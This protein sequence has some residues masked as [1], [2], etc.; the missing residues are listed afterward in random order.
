[1]R[2]VEAIHHLARAGPQPRILLQRFDDQLIDGARQ[3][4]VERGGRLRRFPHQR[5]E[6]R[7]LRRGHERVTAGHQLVQ[8]DSERED[9][10]LRRNGLASSLFGR[11]VANR[12]EDQAR[13]GHRAG[14]CRGNGCVVQ[15]GEAEI[16]QLDV[17][18]GTHH[19]VVRLDVAMN[20]LGGVRDGEGFGNLPGNGDRPTER[21]T[22]CRQRP[23]CH[24]VDELHRHVTIGLDDSRLVD[25]DDVRVIEGGCQRRLAEQAI[26][27]RVVADERAADHLQSR[28]ASEAAVV[29]AID[30]AHAAG[31]ELCEDL[32]RTD[33]RSGGNCHGGWA[34]LYR[35][36]IGVADGD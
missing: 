4:G 5:V 26:E 18:V 14:Q 24:A 20:D 32:V 12:S 15:P 25:R 16:E 35:A 28:V 21:Q 19:H 33:A 23:Q 22:G 6:R 29:G 30:L 17:A 7:N 27:R 34:E 3:I 9:V 36:A 10:R 8:Q 31:A 2:D 11:H 1:M 13:L